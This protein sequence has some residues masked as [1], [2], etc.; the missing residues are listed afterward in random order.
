MRLGEQ[1]DGEAGG[2]GRGAVP[3]GDVAVIA[4]A[5]ATAAARGAR[6]SGRG[7]LGWSSAAAAVPPAPGA[8]GLFLG[9][10]R[11]RAG[12]D[13]G[14]EGDEGCCGRDDAW[15]ASVAADFGVSR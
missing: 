11:L 2:D 6:R 12:G 10:P 4:A 13:E 9:R 3:T 5:A 7:G 14:G 1:A 15:A 8:T